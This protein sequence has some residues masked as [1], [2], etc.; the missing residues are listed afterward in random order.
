MTIVV[1]VKPGD[2]RV[3][4]NEARVASDVQDPDTTNNSA[5][6]T[7]SVRVADVK[8]VK[9]SDADVYKPS[10][11]ITYTL[12]VTNNGPGNAETVKVTDALPLSSQDRVAVLDPA[13]TLAG[14]VA[15]C[16][17]GTLAPLASRTLTIAIIP[18]GKTGQI[19]NTSSVSSRRSIPTH[20]TTHRTG[21]SSQAIRRNRRTAW[22]PRRNARRA[23]L[24]GPPCPRGVATGAPGAFR[25]IG[26][27][28]TP[29]GR[30]RGGLELRRLGAVE[31]R[32]GDDCECSAPGLLVLGLPSRPGGRRHRA[33]QHLSRT[34]G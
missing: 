15:T 23:A 7:T 5:N 8:I 6:A 27:G 12:T 20:Q 24:R 9:T 34:T 17:L 33:D 18:K 28:A 19:S 26:A 14:A 10:S 2:H 21:S 16:N 4:S 31:H 11:K 29:R 22:L 25:Q 32:A 13:C 3:V 1:R 30:L